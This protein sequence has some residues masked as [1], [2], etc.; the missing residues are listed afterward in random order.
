MRK[1][2]A[3]SLCSSLA[4]STTG[5]GLV[6]LGTGALIDKAR[7]PAGNRSEP[8]D[9]HEMSRLGAG[10]GVELTSRETSQTV[11][12]TLRGMERDGDRAIVVVDADDGPRRVD[13]DNIG[14]ARRLRDPKPK[15][16]WKIGLVLGTTVDIIAVC[17]VTS[18]MAGWAA[19]D[20]KYDL[21]NAQWS[22]PH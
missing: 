15:N 2:L 9:L 12:G 6:G 17:A 1:L 21:G 18:V 19:S 10:D 14:E 3:Y 22:T 4:L 8:I 5:C 16:A 7:E 13:Y 20:H 11:R